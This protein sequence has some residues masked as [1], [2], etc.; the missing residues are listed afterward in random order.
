MRKPRLSVQEQVEHMKSQGIQFQCMNE[1]E[2][3]EYLEEST[4]YFK[5][6]AYAK[7]FDKY[8]KAEKKDQYI[9][10]D[11]A[12]LVDLSIIDAGIRRHIL[13]MS[14]DI[15]HYLKVALLRDFNKT[16]ADGYSIVENFIARNKQ[17][18]DDEMKAK[19]R[20][21]ACSNL[22]EKYE[23]EFAIWNFIEVI[24]FRDFEDLY[25]YFYSQYGDELYGKKVGPYK[26]FFHPVR[27]LRNAA[28]H[29]N[30]LINSLRTP[31]VAPEKM[32][33]N[34]QIA[35]FLG[36]SI[37]NKTLNTNLSKPFI[38]DFC[39]M[40]YLYCLVAPKRVR[41][42]MIGELK[43]YFETRV[44]KHQCYYEKNPTLVSAY[45]FLVKAIE[46]FIE[47]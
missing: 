18:F 31:Y 40:I 30:C 10:L 3:A 34:Y 16:H 13:K 9:N 2:A 29:N 24:T 41:I 26:Y 39:V 8:T 4:Y 23:N 25:N 47:F 22:I 1:L 11:F 7:L 21:K 27:I 28:A 19:R 32:N 42:H 38:H 37:H 45:N 33:K 46:A 36:K 35:S 20:G 6:K 15:E 44:V 43:E 12:Y 17:H 5:I 14:L